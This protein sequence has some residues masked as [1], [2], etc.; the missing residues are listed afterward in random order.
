MAKNSLLEKAKEPIENRGRKA[1]EYTNEEEEL[2]MAWLNG[3]ISLSQV[4]RA[5]DIGVVQNAYTFIAL[6]SRQIFQRATNKK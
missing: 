5:M 6:C 2:C 3:E 4:A 1:R